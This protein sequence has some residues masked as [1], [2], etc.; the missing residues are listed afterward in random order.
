MSRTQRS[1]AGQNGFRVFDFMLPI[2]F[3]VREG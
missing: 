3:Y 2:A 1:M